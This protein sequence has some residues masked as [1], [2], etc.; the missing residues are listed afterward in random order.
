MSFLNPAYLWALPLG[1]IP[2]IIYYLMR[3]RSLKVVWGANYVLERALE[4]LKKQLYLDQIILLALRVLACLA[5][6]LLFARPASRDRS[7]VISST[8]VHRVVIVDGSYSML[9]GRDNETRWDVVVSSLK[10]LAKTWGRGEKWSLYLLGKNPRWVVDEAAVV[11]AERTLGSIRSLETSES[12]ASLGEAIES[13]AQKFAAESVE[14]YVLADDQH[15]TWAGI[16]KI[17]LPPTWSERVY[18]VNPPLEDRGNLAVTSVRFANERSLRSHPCRLYVAVR[19]FGAEP[20]QDV[21]VEILVDGAFYGRESVSLLP[22]QEG[23]LFLDIIFEEPGSHYATA[24]VP[25]DALGFDNQLSAGIEVADTISVLVLRSPEKTKTFDSAWGFL[26]IAGRIQKMVDEDE[27]PLFALGPLTFAESQGDPKPEQLRAADVILLDGGSSLSAELVVTL[28][29]YV[30]H[31]GGLVLAPDEKVDTEE[32]NSLLG[33]ARLLPAPLG[34]LTVE[35]LGGE[36]YKALSRSEFDHTAFRPFETDEDGSLSNAKFYSWFE[37]EE[38]P[39][40]TSVLARFSDRKPFLLRRRSDLGCV[41]MTASG[42]NG[43]GNNLIVREFYLPLIFRLFSEAASGAI[44]PRTVARGQAIGLRL[45]EPGE[46]KGMTL[47]SEGED[48]VSL[49]PTESGGELRA[50]AREGASNSGLCSIL[51]IRSDGSSRVYYGVHGPRTDSDLAAMS[52]D[53]RKYATDR[54]KF[55]EVSGWQELDELLRSE[56]SAHEWHHWVALLLLAI[57]LSEML[58]ELRFV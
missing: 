18:W 10:E 19:N 14:L 49:T 13:V 5:I 48:P 32:W 11:D 35:T 9:A 15:S 24:R 43:L 50:I 8:G 4:R 56:R 30:S 58:M 28:A 40:D 39:K 41:M 53:L 52:P 45:K 33:K 42:L 7:G 12:S 27:E 44:Y 20:A 21:D 22:G 26:Q 25:T 3:Y 37:F 6:V 17:T 47:T 2:I 38:V 29:E 55:A 31:G 51:V 16:D 57:F 46:V 34:R 54:L 36:K 23:W 1:S